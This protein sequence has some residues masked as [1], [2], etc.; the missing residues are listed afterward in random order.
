[1]G[2]F[3]TAGLPL[4]D[5]YLIWMGNEAGNRIPAGL[6][7]FTVSIPVGSHLPQA[8][9]FAMALRYRK[10]TS[11]VTA[12]FGD[13]A[14]S[15]GDFSEAL[16][17]AG[18]FRAP[19]VFICVNNQYAIS[20]PLRKQTAA[21]T[22]AQKAGAY[23]FPGIQVDG[24]DAL[25]M[26]AATREALDRARTGG[27]PTL[28]EAL[29][30][31]MS[32]HTTSDDASRYRTKEEVG[33]WSKKDP[34]ERYR[35]Y[36]KGKG[37]WDEDFE[38]RVNREAEDLVNRAVEEAESSPPPPPE[39]YFVHTYKDMPPHLKVELDDLKDFLKEGG[40]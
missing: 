29:T 30:Y 10:E 13:G 15:E 16:N 36:L 18:V 1:L 9:G 32:D 19:I 5:Y 7:I 3:I 11:A 23:G 31:R 28:I 25:A 35:T 20:T 6:N 40:R 38:A 39:D 8:V 21:R 34:L 17:F 24:N 26:Y 2:T 33:E 37:L 22:I 12:Y 4:K 27:G 14:T